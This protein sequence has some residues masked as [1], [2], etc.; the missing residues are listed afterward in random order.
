MLRWG[1]R[2]QLPKV[3][4]KGGTRLFVRALWMGLWHGFVAY[5]SAFAGTAVGVGAA[6][7]VAAV[8]LVD[9][10]QEFDK[11]ARFVDFG[12]WV[13]AVVTAGAGMSLF[14][15]GAVMGLAFRHLYLV[16]RVHL[17][18]GLLTAFAYFLPTVW[19][20]VGWI[21]LPAALLVW[22]G[23]RA[24]ETPDSARI[25]WLL[26]K[27]YRGFPELQDWIREY[28]LTAWMSSSR[29]APQPLPQTEPP[30]V[31]TAAANRR[32]LASSLFDEHLSEMSQMCPR[33]K[34]S[35]I[36]DEWGA[37]IRTSERIHRMVGAD[38]ERYSLLNHFLASQMPTAIRL[39]WFFVKADGLTESNPS[40]AEHMREIEAGLKGLLGQFEKVQNQ[41]AESDLEGLQALLRVLNE[42]LKQAEQREASA[43]P[44]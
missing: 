20:S 16:P 30:S 1:G 27:Y 29:P 15:M 11:H 28:I 31:A 14:L 17:A 24:L 41:M 37:L 7:L 32:G 33:L 12:A 40:R 13:I 35:V 26:H 8:G 39:G 42:D 18:V 4:P 44:L 5:G 23:L 3:R 34:G 22:W 36:E 9:K 2:L 6:S 10:L 19:L 43:P 21:V 25:E 38:A